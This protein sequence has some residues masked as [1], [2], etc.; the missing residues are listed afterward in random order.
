VCLVVKYVISVLVSLFLE[1]CLDLF[2]HVA[3]NNREK[4]VDFEGLLVTS[5]RLIRW[6]WM[7]TNAVTRS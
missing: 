7:V 3:I 2:C 4:K 6:A 1:S 5:I